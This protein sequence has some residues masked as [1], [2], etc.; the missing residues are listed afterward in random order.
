MENE[1]A[2]K[3]LR[4]VSDFVRWGA[5]RFER[6]GLHFGHGTD[7]AIDEA[8]FLVAS[9]LGVDRELSPALAARV[10][11]GMEK[12]AVVALLLRRV[13][14]RRPA[15]YLTQET[16]FA[17][18]E[19]Q[20]D[21]RVLIPRSPIAELID[22]CF[23]PWVEPDKVSRILDLCTGSGC[24]GIACAHAFPS[25]VVDCTDISEDALAV[26][27]L[28]IERY[29]LADRVTAIRSDLFSGLGANQYDLI[30]SNPPYVPTESLDALPAE[31]GY[32][33]RVGLEAGSSGLTVVVEL[34]LQAP[35]HLSGDGVL[36][37]EVGESAE[38]LERAFP[39]ASFVWLDFRRGGDGVFVISAAELT[40]LSADAR[41]IR[42]AG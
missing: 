38:D 2:Y 35:A 23:I 24:I 14:E 17:G 11:T 8:A 26:A 41:R 34:L 39:H 37:C 36:V 19:F 42:N 27:A 22:E 10:L 18:L 7:N 29:D 31:Y 9:A 28:N 5:D 20:V 6:A 3:S 21:E 4:D 13:R 15:A 1:E 33:P 40:A 16:R 12:E 32:E 30:V 25:A